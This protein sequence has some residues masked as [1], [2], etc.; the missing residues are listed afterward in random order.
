MNISILGVIV[1]SVASMILGSL[2]YSPVLFGKLWAK[3]SGLSKAQLKK[4]HKK[5]GWT[6]GLTFL[7]TIV[8]SVFM[9][10][11]IEYIYIYT[12]VKSL[13]LGAQLGFW[14]WLG[15]VAT[16]SLGGVVY[17]RKSIRVYLIN[18]AYN[19]LSLMLIGALLSVM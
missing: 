1:A 6:Y 12:D 18:N 14:M 9:A 2:W 5:A 13:Q 19:L 3:E 16:V 8:L 10:Y 7:A 4:M 17:E 11:I 15:F